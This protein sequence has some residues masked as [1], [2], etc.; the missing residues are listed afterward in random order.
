MGITRLYQIF[1]LL[2]VTNKNP[3]L[4]EEIFAGI[5]FLEFFFGHFVGINFLEFEFT[6]DFAGINIREL[7]LTRDFAGIFAN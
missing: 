4:R 5:N 3:T 1:C 2:N 7:S 6:E